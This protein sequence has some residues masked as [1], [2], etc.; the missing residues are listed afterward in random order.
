MNPLKQEFSWPVALEQNEIV[1]VNPADPMNE[2]RMAQNTEGTFLPGD[3]TTRQQTKRVIVKLAPGERRM[4]IGEAAY[5]TVPRIF[6]ALVREKYGTTKAGLARLRNPATQK[7]LLKEIVVGPVI[8]N[9][10]DAM[11]TYVNDKMKDIEGFSDVQVAPPKPR[12]F[13]NPEVLAKA[14]ATRNAN[15]AAKTQPA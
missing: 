10:A 3:S 6:N 2:E 12:G 4:I 7:E 15:K 9:V 1:G 14:Q 5:V 8:N 11:Q 13:S